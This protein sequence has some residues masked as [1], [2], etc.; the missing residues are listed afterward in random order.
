MGY[1]ESRFRSFLTLVERNHI[2]R[3][4]DLIPT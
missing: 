1:E 4:W 2:A 3:A